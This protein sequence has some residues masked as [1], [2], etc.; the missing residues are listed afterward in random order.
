MKQIKQVLSLVTFVFVQSASS[1]VLYTLNPN[2]VFC[3]GN[4]EWNASQIFNQSP[5]DT[6]TISISPA[7]SSIRVF[8][9]GCDADIC[10]N[11]NVVLRSARLEYSHLFNN[12]IFLRKAEIFSQSHLGDN[13]VN[14]CISTV[15]NDSFFI[16]YSEKYFSR[17]QDLN[18]PG[19]DY[20]CIVR[21][22]L[23]H[24]IAHFLNHNIDRH[25]RTSEAEKNADI[26]A[27]AT[28]SRIPEVTKE[29]LKIAIVAL[30]GN[31]DD[32]VHGEI[33]DRIKRIDSMYEILEIGENTP[34]QQPW[35]SMLKCELS[36]TA[37]FLDIRYIKRCIDS[38]ANPSM[39]GLTG[40]TP[41]HEAARIDDLRFARK[42]LGY[43]VPINIKNKNNATPLLI[44]SFYRKMK[45]RNLLLRVDSVDRLAKTRLSGTN[46]IKCIKDSVG[47]KIMNETKYIQPPYD[48]ELSFRSLLSSDGSFPPYAPQIIVDSINKY[49]NVNNLPANTLGY[50]STTILHIGA[51]LGNASLITKGLRNNSVNAQTKK[52]RTPL[53]CAVMSGN[54]E[55]IRQFFSCCDNESIEPELLKTDCEGR[56]A[57]D[58][59]LHSKEFYTQL[60]DFIY[61][62]N[63]L[64]DNDPWEE[65]IDVI[66]RAV[67]AMKSK[68]THVPNIIFAALHDSVSIANK[69]L[70]NDILKD[71]KLPLQVYVNTTMGRVKF[72]VLLDPLTIAIICGSRQ[73]AVEILKK[74]PTEN[75]IIGKYTAID[76]AEKGSFLDS[77]L[78][79][80]GYEREKYK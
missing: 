32:I 24:E 20:N 12:S 36:R 25:E 51:Y 39:V 40:W 37:E 55:N 70:Q 54:I 18:T 28:M 17:F 9:V 63:K 67:N 66:R 10:D 19:L 48:A 46:V 27:I 35:D 2:S 50:D 15:C 61:N 1:Q 16:F 30:S 21:F 34:T 78:T 62:R 33:R 6:T 72:T 8:A 75:N 29:K 76:F 45:V 77:L 5:S 41:L 22:S 65:N 4:T 13:R 31:G 60:C 73:V 59:A 11:Y 68:R 44:A 57:F 23:A 80:N 64:N 58:Y 47:L 79:E 74:T 53:M 7:I 52:K 26:F 56:N 38:G 3:F 69:S 42:L 14:A 43:N 49:I 71:Y